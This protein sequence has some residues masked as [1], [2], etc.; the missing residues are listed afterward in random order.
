MFTVNEY[1]CDVLVL[2]GG[3]AG[4]RAAWEAGRAKA[5]VLVLTKEGAGK[6]GCTVVATAAYA[7]AFQD[8]GDHPDD[9][10][11]DA[12]RMGQDLNDREL[13]RL[14]V[15]NSP[16][17]LMELY[18]LGAKLV[19]EDARPI[20]CWKSAQHSVTRSF[21]AVSGTHLGM[22]MLSSLLKAAKAAGVCFLDR[23]YV[24]DLIL[25]DG[26]VAGCIG[27]CQDKAELV[28]VK[29]KSTVLATGGGS[30][31]YSRTD[32]PKNIVGDGHAMAW[33]VGAEMVD[34]EFVL[35]HHTV[36]VR[37]PA[38]P[39]MIP[40]F[41]T[42]LRDGALV[43]NRHGEDVAQKYSISSFREVPRDLACQIMFKEIK[44]GRGIG[45][46]LWLDASKLGDTFLEE[47]YP[48]LLK[49]FL[50]Q[51]VDIRKDHFL[52]GP[53]SHAFVGGCRINRLCE[54]TVPGLYAAGETVGGIHG[55]CELPGNNLPDTQVFGAIAGGQAATRARSMGKKKWDVPLFKKAIEELNGLEGPTLHD[56][57]QIIAELK[58]VMWEKAGV[59]KTESSLKEAQERLDRV[60]ELLPGMKVG[61]K[62]D[63][64]KLLSLKSI[65]EV[66]SLLV[67]AAQERKE[68]RGP[69]FRED[70][71]ARDDSR[72]LGNIV[73]KR[74]ADGT[75]GTDFR[76]LLK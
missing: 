46:G 66:G 38:S 16:K 12:L 70:F 68:S 32:N 74:K 73:L 26:G 40:T 57:T 51:G 60:R 65:L 44:A 34:M 35:F 13:L 69:H 61:K 67:A 19:Q 48:G 15:N 71:P 58:E 17:R 6:S 41:Y 21:R 47:K 52:V 53:G 25:S 11:A 8:L 63:L 28:V 14:L 50:M 20:P 55:A 59:I 22:E 27:V 30:A 62:E 43:I 76:P 4:L 29:A 23:V 37:P 24:T 1:E 3:G 54:T 10:F 5:K 18:Q 9:H 39:W 49:T 31:I 75:V 2:G 45:P 72:F 42:L 7:A 56:L 36:G 33:R 64:Y